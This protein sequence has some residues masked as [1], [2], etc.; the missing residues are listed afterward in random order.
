MRKEEGEGYSEDMSRWE[1]VTGP[2]DW[3][4]KSVRMGGRL[5]RGRMALHKVQL[6]FACSGQVDAVELALTDR[7]LGLV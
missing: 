4:G 7:R 2:A 3:P 1:G 5:G 6:N